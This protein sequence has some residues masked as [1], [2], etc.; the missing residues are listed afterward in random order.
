MI[1]N[2]ANRIGDLLYRHY[3][4][5]E[6][7]ENAEGCGALL[8][9]WTVRRMLMKV[10]AD[11]VPVFRETWRRLY[12]GG[13]IG[14]PKRLVYGDIDVGV[15]IERTKDAR[16]KVIASTRYCSCA[17]DNTHL[18]IL[19]GDEKNW[20]FV[21]RRV[22]PRENRRGG[23]RVAVSKKYPDGW[24]SWGDYRDIKTPSLATYRRLDFDTFSG[25][26]GWVFST[27]RFG[28]HFFQPDGGLEAPVVFNALQAL[29]WHFQAAES[30]A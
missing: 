7:G 30:R 11:S 2:T 9:E 27:S 6:R 12:E 3:R 25:R 23:Y 20:T 14:E 10:I 18:Y 26:D 22:W 13:H 29:R 16:R 1:S 28:K 24:F 19:S 17:D 21:C 15:W 8:L 4:I 5:A